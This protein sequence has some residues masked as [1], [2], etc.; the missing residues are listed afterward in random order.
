MSEKSA[1][2]GDEDTGKGAVEQDRPEQ[3]GNVSMAGQ[4]GHRNQDPLLKAN[5]S[6]YPEPGQNPE[7]TGE[8][9]TDNA[10]DHDT[11]V[12]CADASGD[13]TP[14]ERQKENQNQSKDD[15]LAA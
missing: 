15:P 13:E 1:N 3:E 8:P 4:I 11:E 5:D 14:G 9:Q 2:V 10:L 12:S 6:D 7:H